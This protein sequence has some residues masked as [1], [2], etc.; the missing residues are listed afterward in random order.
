V[1]HEPSPPQPDF[2]V[3]NTHPRPGVGPPRAG[4][5]SSAEA[6]DGPGAAPRHERAPSSARSPNGFRPDRGRC[7]DPDPEIETMYEEL[8]G[9]GGA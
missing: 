3:D 4:P 1:L 2:E 9:E 6:G 7:P 8:G 5:E